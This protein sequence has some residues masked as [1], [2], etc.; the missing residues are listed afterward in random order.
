L[1]PRQ[2]EQSQG[3]YERRDR[4]R[5]MSDQT[6]AWRVG[7]VESD[8][9][10]VRIDLK[11]KFNEVREDIKEID[12]KMDLAFSESGSVGKLAGRINEFDI[13]KKSWKNVMMIFGAVS[14][15]FGGAVTYFVTKVVDLFV[16]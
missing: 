16:K 15:L 4:D 5:R 1:A 13:S 11:E 3:N 14:T 8:I 6:L 12:R 2:E 7:E 10:E 9:R